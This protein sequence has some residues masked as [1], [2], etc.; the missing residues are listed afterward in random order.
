M[1]LTW[2][3]M[4]HLLL[5]LLLILSQPPWSGLLMF[6]VR[7]IAVVLFL[8]VLARMVV[9]WRHLH[10]AG[11]S[12]FHYLLEWFIPLLLVGLSLLLFCS[13]DRGSVD[14]LFQQVDNVLMNEG[15]P[16]HAPA[17][18]PG[19]WYEIPRETDEGMPE[20]GAPG[21]ESRLDK[22]SE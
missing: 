2:V 18:H 11:A 10:R 9:L 3:V 12:V 5:E 16:A 22:R 1:S 19:G 17:F 13:Q 8:L 4:A 7:A 15:R 6:L 21:L 14:H 20:A